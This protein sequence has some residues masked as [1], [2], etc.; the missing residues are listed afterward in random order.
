MGTAALIWLLVSI[1]AE[2]TSF[3]QGIGFIEVLGDI[4]SGRAHPLVTIQ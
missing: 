3:V 4:G 1:G 2:R